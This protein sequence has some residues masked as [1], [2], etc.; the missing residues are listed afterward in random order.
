M[1]PEITN[2]VG[3][4]LASLGGIWL[5]VIEI[6]T[7]RT[8]GFRQF[9]VNALL[10]DVE[11]WKDRVEE[12]RTFVLETNKRLGREVHT[13]EVMAKEALDGLAS[14]ERELAVEEAPLEV[15]ARV[16]GPMPQQIAALSVLVLGF[17]LQ[18][19]AAIWNLACACVS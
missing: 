7:R 11:H 12:L 13:P 8:E 16:M 6:R 17:I 9:R 14:A 1:L 3:L 19:F 18:L 5:V 10:K 4:V 15:S 2:V